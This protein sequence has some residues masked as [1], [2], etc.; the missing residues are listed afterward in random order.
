ML[1]LTVKTGEAIAIGNSAVVKV[2]DK[3]GQ[4]VRL[5]VAT[6]RSNP[7]KIIP[8]GIIPPRFAFGLTAKQTLATDTNSQIL[9]PFA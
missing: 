2:V 7:V 8:T 1:S 4:R 6:R 3:S 5:I 9:L